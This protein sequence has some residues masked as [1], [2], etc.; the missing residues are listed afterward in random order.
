MRIGVT[1]VVTAALVTL[2]IHTIRF[3]PSPEA[4]HIQSKVM[5]I[6]LLAALSSVYPIILKYIWRVWRSGEKS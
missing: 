3:L 4:I 6:L 2:T 1:A 5:A